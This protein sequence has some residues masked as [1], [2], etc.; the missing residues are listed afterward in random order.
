MTPNDFLALREMLKTESGLV[1]TEDKQYLLES[2]LSPLV[3]KHGFTSVQDL[4]QKWRRGADKALQSRIVE[5]MTINESFFFRDKSP[6][7]NFENHMLKDLIERNKTS[8]HIR[9]WSAAAS[10][11]QEAY[12]LAMIL[13]E[14]A[15]EL[16]GWKVEIIGTDL[17][18]DALEKAKTG[19]Y[20]QFEVQRGLPI[21][22]LIKYFT[23]D[24]ES[25]QINEDIRSM[26]T[27]RPY[28]LLSSFSA[29][30]QFDVIFCRNV[31]IYFDKDTK[32]DVL[33]RMK[34]IIPSDGA[35]FLGAAETVLGI[36]DEFKP[37]RGQRG[38]Y[39]PSDGSMEFAPA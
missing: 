10:T 1:L 7:D 17:C 13:K 34:E 6:F 23:Q 9:I 36:T 30:G 16:Q 25:W 28:N 8:R 27:F 3:K 19:I 21:N 11:G 14:Y 31:L 22:Q 24:G 39:V 15:T 29:L 20:S 2:R 37:V 4:V 26:V 12:S 32:K 18:S 35:L 33:L 38:L 5:A